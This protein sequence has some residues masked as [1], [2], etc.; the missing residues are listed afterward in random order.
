MDPARSSQAGGYGIGLSMAKAIVS[1]HGGKIQ[2]AAEE[3]GPAL[4]IT[5][6]LPVLSERT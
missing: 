5:V 4:R 3:D 6:Q 2:A 1:A